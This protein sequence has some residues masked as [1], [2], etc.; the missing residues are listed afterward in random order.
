MKITSTCLAVLATLFLN[1][2]FL[3]AQ[4]NVLWP[5][6]PSV[7][8]LGIGAGVNFNIYNTD[9]QW[10]PPLPETPLAAYKSGTGFS[11]WVTVFGD[12]ALNKQFGVQLGL[13]FDQKRFGNT[14]DAKGD[15]VFKDGRYNPG[16][17]DVRLDYDILINYLGISLAGR[18]NATPQLFVT[19]GPF[20]EWR[21]DSTRQIE[22]HSILSSDGYSYSDQST[23]TFEE[24]TTHI[25]S[26][27]SQRTGL[28]LHLGYRIPAGAA[29]EIVPTLGFQYYLT[30]LIEDR[31]SG[32]Q[33]RYKTIGT[34]DVWISNSFLHSA[35]LGVAFTFGI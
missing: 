27:P 13:S 25:Q 14:L 1:L 4:E 17:T 29:I 35:Q 34:S 10:T 33:F 12:Y 6:L 31:P 23:V 7:V 26:E 24:F 3:S 15:V 5:R 19:F 16:V 2:S 8:R 11:P 21:L 20:T 32:D 30:P 9:M 22:S 18:W 28:A